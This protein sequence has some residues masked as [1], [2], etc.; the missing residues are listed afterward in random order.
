M[1]KGRSRY[2][3]GADVITK[4]RILF[5]VLFLTLFQL[6]DTPTISQS[7]SPLQ[8]PHWSLTLRLRLVQRNLASLGDFRSRRCAQPSYQLWL[9]T[10][11]AAGVGSPELPS[12]D[13]EIPDIFL[14]H[15]HT[16]CHSLQRKSCMVS[17]ASSGLTSELGGKVSRGE[18]RRLGT[19]T[20]Q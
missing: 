3:W 19:H 17:S 4:V 7:L 6:G 15:K 1:R 20:L 9:L 16:V 14:R 13:N 2:G 11:P 18:W 10:G 8:S 12:S 5:P